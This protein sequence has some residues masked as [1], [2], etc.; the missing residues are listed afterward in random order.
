VARYSRHSR[1]RPKSS[2]GS[3][4]SLLYFGDENDSGISTGPPRG[5]TWAITDSVFTARSAKTAKGR[6]RATSPP[7]QVP[8]LRT[9]FRG[10]AVYKRRH[11]ASFDIDIVGAIANHR[12]RETSRNGQRFRRCVASDLPTVGGI[13]RATRTKSSAAK[14]APITLSRRRTPAK[15][16]KK[17]KLRLG[18]QRCVDVRAEK[19]LKPAA[20]DMNPK[21]THQ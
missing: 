16:T 10:N 1:Q 4:L 12:V 6:P 9:S 5:G 21:A 7:N 13:Y 3:S 2:S 20:A 15:C 18:C 8:E 17:P 14:T 11:H 19:R